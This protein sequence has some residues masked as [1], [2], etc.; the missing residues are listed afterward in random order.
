MVFSYTGTMTITKVYNPFN[1]C[2]TKNLCCLIIKRPT[3]DLELLSTINKIATMM[4]SK[5]VFPLRRDVISKH[6]RWRLIF[7]FVF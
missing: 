6:I 7:L 3:K 5:S 1:D 4:V 2:S